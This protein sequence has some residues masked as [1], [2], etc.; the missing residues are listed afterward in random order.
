L[1]QNSQHN[2]DYQFRLPTIFIVRASPDSYRVGVKP[3]LQQNLPI[4]T[5]LPTDNN[6]KAYRQEKVKVKVK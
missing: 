2:I 4:P 6:R 3:S 5:T 1:K